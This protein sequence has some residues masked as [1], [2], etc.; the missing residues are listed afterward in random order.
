MVCIKDHCAL[1][2][3]ME[4]RMLCALYIHRSAEKPQTCPF[5]CLEMNVYKPLDF[6]EHMKVKHMEKAR[7]VYD[8]YLFKFFPQSKIFA[9]SVLTQTETAGNKLSKDNFVIRCQRSQ[10]CGVNP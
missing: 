10:C 8:R 9:E 7:I 2:A 4:G 6:L 1:H 5:C 3:A